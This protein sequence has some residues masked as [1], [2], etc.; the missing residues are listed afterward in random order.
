MFIDS[1]RLNTF[2]LDAVLPVRVHQMPPA[3][4]TTSTEMEAVEDH[5]EGGVGALHAD[6]GQ[7][8]TPRVEPMK[9]V[10]EP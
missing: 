9:D 5:F 4:R 7:R 2:G 6:V 10:D 1:R 8:V 3:S